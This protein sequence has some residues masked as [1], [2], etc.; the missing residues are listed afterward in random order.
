MVGSAQPPVGPCRGARTGASGRESS[1]QRP[2]GVPR[3]RRNSCSQ[4]PSSGGWPGAPSLFCP[5]SAPLPASGSL[6]GSLPAGPV[7]LPASVQPETWAWE[8]PRPAPWGPCPQQPGRKAGCHI[9]TPLP[10]GGG[11]QEVAGERARPTP[12]KR[13]PEANLKFTKKR[14]MTKSE[15]QCNKIKNSEA[16]NYSTALKKNK[17]ENSSKVL[18]NINI[19]DKRTKINGLKLKTNQTLKC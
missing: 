3:P 8:W 17:I 18:K 10:A 1:V 15:R 16:E 11:P 6:P 13:P 12:D 19:R 5:P 14:K 9:V 2:L 7:C 4:F